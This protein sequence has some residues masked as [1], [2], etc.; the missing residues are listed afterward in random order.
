MF[1]PGFSVPGKSPRTAQ[2][3]IKTLNGVG[4]VDPIPYFL[5]VLQ[6][7]AE[8]GPIV[9]PGLRDFGVSTGGRMDCK[10]G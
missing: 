5:G 8:I 10:F 6:I 3:A 2:L 7:A 4:G 9:S 1:F